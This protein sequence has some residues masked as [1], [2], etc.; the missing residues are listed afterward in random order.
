MTT[1]RALTLALTAALALA[2]LAP[3]APVVTAQEDPHFQAYVAE[4]TL[5]PGTVQTLEVTIVNRPRDLGDGVETARNVKVDFREGG[6][7]FTILSGTKVLGE[8]PDGVYRT[9]TLR[10]KVHED[11]PAGKYRIPID[12]THEFDLRDR[13]VRTTH[14]VVFVEPRARFRVDATESTV[15][16]AG[17]GT[18]TVA[19]TNVGEEAATNAAVTLRS[20]SADVRFGRSDAA[21]R[22]VGVWEPNETRV[23]EYEAT[24]GDGAETRSYT[25]HATV[26]Y[27]DA[28]GNPATSRALPLGMTPVPEQTFAVRNVD[29]TLRVG[30]E[31]TLTGEVVNAGDRPA[32]N[33]VVV[34]AGTT[35]TV[36]AV[37]R[38]YALGTLEPGA[39]GAFRF[40]LEASA[41]AEAGP[42][43]L[44]LAVEY[45]DLDDEP[46]TSDDLDVRAQV[47]ERRDEF[48]VVAL[49]A[50]LTAGSSGQLR[51]AVTNT[52]EEPVTDV[53]AK[54]YLEEPLSSSDDEAFVERLAPGETATLTF[55]AGATGGAVAK[56]YPVQVDVRYDDADGDTLISDTYQLAVGV[57]VSE[58]G[59]GLPVTLLGAG[60]AALVV[61]GGVLA[62]RRREAGEADVDADADVKATADAD[63]HPDRSGDGGSAAGDGAEDADG[64]EGANANA[65][66]AASDG[67]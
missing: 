29:S 18:V 13:D 40:D 10:L 20:R 25:L 27:D 57:A 65:G 38:E 5:T 48:D 14:A 62:W 28:D 16:V 44:S 31:G 30:E 54:L 6:R 59:S 39:A 11:A 50:T 24:A 22:F 41:D 12:V 36:S 42:R 7:P 60:A 55:E 64:A 53:S 37:E 2:L 9:T 52:L 34:L 1:R 35:G 61:V 51:L 15:A 3:A 43:Q 23:L 66:T 32:R 67:E 56:D 45:R 63:P 46:R 19:M 4:N 26:D 33:A 58:R 21:S 8:M 47:G 17:T 49:D